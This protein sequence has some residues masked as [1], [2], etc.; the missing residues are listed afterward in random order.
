VVRIVGRYVPKTEAL[1][2]WDIRGSNDCLNRVFKLN[3]LPYG[4]YPGEDVVDRRGKKPATVTEEDPTQEAAPATKKRKLGTGVGELGVSDSFAM[5]LMGTCAALGGRMSSPELRESS[6]RMLEVTGGRWPKNVPISRAAGEDFFTSRM[7]RDLRVFPYGWNIA[8]VV[9]SVMNKDR[10]DAA[11]KRRAVVRMV[12]P[13]RKA[14]RARGSAK[15]AGSDSSKPVPAAK[16]ATPEASKALMGEKAAA[17]GGT[18]PPAGGPSP[19]KLPPSGKR[20]A[21]FGTNISVEDYLVG[22][23]FFTGGMLQGRAR[24]NWLLSRLRWQP[25]RHRRW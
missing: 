10:Q 24:D 19:A 7:A 2:S 12:D 6:A 22:K 5:E 9:S 20:V 17:A 8:A 1:R 21:D 11:Q 14:K 18:K 25:P 3:R 4:G 13:V 16:P 23:Y 15:A